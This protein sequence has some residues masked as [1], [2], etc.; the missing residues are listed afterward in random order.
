MEVMIISEIASVYG[1]IYLKKRKSKEDVMKNFLVCLLTAG[2]IFVFSKTTIAGDAKKFDFIRPVTN[3]IYFDL[4]VPQTYIHPIFIYQ[5]L[6]KKVEVNVGETITQVPVDGHLT[7]TALAFEYAVSE[8]LSIV[9]AKDGYINFRPKETLNKATGFADLAAGV[10]Y[11][12]ILNPADKLALSGK[13]L[14]ELPTGNKKVFQG[15]GDGNISPSV[16]LTKGFGNL[17]LAAT[18]G[19]TIPFD[20]GKE[21]TMLYDSW[22]L[23]YGIAKRFYPLIELNHFRVLSAGKGKADF[24]PINLED[25]ATF[26]GGD[27]INLGAKH[28][29]RNKDFTTM[30]A[31]FRFKIT[32][33]LN[34]GAAYE[35]PLTAKEK[36]LMKNWN[37]NIP[38]ISPSDQK[39]FYAI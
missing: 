6:P 38:A 23:S 8:R 30:A 7:V 11:A 32:D 18:I 22:H 21:S 19:A 4:A 9:A 34:I 3:P 24:T 27:L 33:N 12:F 10:K 20:S 15:N 5:S 37:R 28:A 29:G 13:V 31:G 26:E 25:L 16:L 14:I 39:S 2:M 17:Q 35:F 36:G 1:S